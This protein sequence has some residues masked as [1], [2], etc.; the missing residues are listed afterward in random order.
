M[1]RL[2]APESFGVMTIGTL[3]LIG[4]TMMS[5]VGLRQ[6]LVRS[7]RAE[8]PSY[9]DAIW[10]LQL[11]RGGVVAAG[12]GIAAYVLSAMQLHADSAYAQPELPW[13]LAGLAAVAL[14]NG[15][16]S[17]KLLLAERRLQNRRVIFIDFA[18]QV[19]GLLGTLSW[20]T[21]SPTVYALL[22]GAILSAGVRVI[23]TQWGLP[24]PVNRLR[25]RREVAQEV[26]HFGTWIALT[27]A[28]GF[29]ISSG[30]RLLL[31]GLLSV[32]ELGQYAIAAL[33]LGALQELTAK[34][35]GSVAFPALSEAY[36]TQPDQLRD[37]YY[38]SRWPIDALCL[39]G[40]G[41]L[42][43]LGPHLIELLYDQRYQQAGGYLSVLALTLVASRYTVA[44]QVY[45]VL[46][47]PQYA[48]VLQV[49]RL[50][51]LVGG[52][53]GGYAV[54]GTDGA[55]IG[56]VLSYWSGMFLNLTWL[57]PRFGLL[58]YRKEARSLWFAA[59]GWAAGEVFSHWLRS[60]S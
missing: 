54:A 42:Y 23:A 40:A 59:A 47:K 22:A 52:V 34:L 37:V 38:R 60:M 12:L 48:F 20:A 57:M 11:M 10:T 43:A 53:W 2:L 27:S 25:W 46:G 13:L 41:G 26:V 18:A 6:V 50:L 35:V 17:T 3:L 24:G 28:V 21:W 14:L 9:L 4:L 55:V 44:S 39:A 33:L 58:D 45:F 29:F 51:S 16:E 32:A 49:V 5:D 36:R 19:A 7:P 30:D 1:A 31:G 56:V 15:L 8:R